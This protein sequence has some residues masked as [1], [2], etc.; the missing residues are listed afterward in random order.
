MRIIVVSNQSGEK[1]DVLFTDDC[2]TPAADYCDDDQTVDI[3]EQVSFE[4]PSCFPMEHVLR[5]RTL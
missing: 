1:E 4:M 2:E 5:K 3:D